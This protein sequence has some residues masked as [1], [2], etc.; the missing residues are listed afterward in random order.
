MHLACQGCGVVVYTKGVEHATALEG[1]GQV[2]LIK[3]PVPLAMWCLELRVKGA[4]MLVRVTPLMGTFFLRLLSSFFFSAQHA[5][6]VI[7]FFCSHDLYSFGYACLRPLGVVVPD[8]A[9]RVRL[10]GAHFQPLQCVQ[11]ASGYALLCFGPFHV[12]WTL[13]IR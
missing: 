6:L 10:I 3:F 7:I 13:L 11:A 9:L 1:W 5:Y 2:L 12:W 8:E 4:S